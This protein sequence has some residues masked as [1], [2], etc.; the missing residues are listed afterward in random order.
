MG[1]QKTWNN[2]ILEKK[3]NSEDSYYLSTR[4]FTI[5]KEGECLC[6]VCNSVEVLVSWS[7]ETQYY[8]HSHWLHMALATGPEHNS[9]RE[10]RKDKGQ[11][12]H[13]GAS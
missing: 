10:D 5:Y 2:S 6:S 8:L 4:F 9:G 13:Q 1:S 7:G 11:W 3:T 12:T